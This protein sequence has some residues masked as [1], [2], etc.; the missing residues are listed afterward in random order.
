[1]LKVLF[2]IPLAED[3]KGG[4]LNATLPSLTGVL[5]ANL[6]DQGEIDEKIT[7]LAQD[8]GSGLVEGGDLHAHAMIGAVFQQGQEVAIAADQRD[9]IHC[10]C[11]YHAHNVHTEIKVQV[12]F[13]SSAG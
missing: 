11:I 13:F 8:G 4:S 3:T 12:G 7:A 1:M 2:P 10:A 6:F 5:G 9:T